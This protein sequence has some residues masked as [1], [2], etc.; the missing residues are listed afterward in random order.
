MAHWYGISIVVWGTSATLP[1]VSELSRLGEIIARSYP[2]G[3]SVHLVV[4]GA[5]PP[6]REARAALWK[7]THRAES[8]LVCTAA[9]VEGQGFRAGLIRS[10]MTSLDLVTGHRLKLRAF[11]DLDQLA[12]WVLPMHNLALG[13]ELSPAELVRAL[14]WLRAQPAVGSQCAS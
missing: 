5:G 9:W 1:L 10:L 8:R 2:R 12:A 4:N 11:T 7:L 6:T 13:L 3:S 14:G